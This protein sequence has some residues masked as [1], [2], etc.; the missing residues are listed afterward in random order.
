MDKFLKIYEE[1]IPSNVIVDRDSIMNCM[2]IAYEMGVSETE[3]KYQHMK[4]G[5]ETIIEDLVDDSRCVTAKS[6]SVYNKKK[7]LTT[8]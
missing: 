3:K 2:E 7:T 4:N 8:L 6:I 5:Y 1:N